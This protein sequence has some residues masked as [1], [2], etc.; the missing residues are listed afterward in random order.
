MKKRRHLW[1]L[2]LAVIFLAVTSVPTYAWMKSSNK[3]MSQRR[4]SKTSPVI[5][6]PGSSATV[7]RFNGLVNE[8]N[9]NR[10]VK[11]SL[12]KVQVDTDGKLE[13]SGSINRND[14]EPIIVIGFEN[15][16]D[17]YSNIKKQAAWLDDAFYQ[18]TNDY[19]FHKFK[20]FGHSNGGLVWTYWLEHYYS[21]YSSEIKMKRLMTL[22]S[23][24]NFK[25]SSIKMKTQM[26]SDFLKYKKRLPSDLVVYSLLG[27]KTYTSDGLVPEGSVLAA[28]YIFQNQV[29]SYTAINITGTDAQHSSLPQNK[30][31]V[32]LIKQY[33][34]DKPNDNAKLHLKIKDK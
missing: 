16:H 32:Q 30:Q 22:G 31:V 19:H 5:M 26:F 15:N 23:P 12:L 6:I 11:H 4:R 20:A 25:E 14:R 7:N 8:L 10:R 13:Y 3:E 17:G 9:K 27:G 33:L 1:L 29:K 18:L 21:G 2:V 28:K 24:Y 34:L